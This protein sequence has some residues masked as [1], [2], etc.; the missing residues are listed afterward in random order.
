MLEKQR[1]RNLWEKFRLLATT[2]I[3]PHTK[4]GKGVR[5]E[6]LWP[7]E[8]DKKTYKEPKMTKERLTY[9]QERSKKFRRNG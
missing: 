3:T 2:L 4:K 6:Q 1:D 9:L 7:F 8:W 5:P